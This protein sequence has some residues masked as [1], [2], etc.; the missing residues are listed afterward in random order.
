MLIQA[1]RNFVP[2]KFAHHAGFKLH[3]L[4][5]DSFGDRQLLDGR[6]LSETVP[7]TFPFDFSN[8]N[9]KLDNSCPESKGS[10]TLF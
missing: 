5:G 2:V 3:R 8:S 7:K 10:G 4:T 9:L 6:F 1:D